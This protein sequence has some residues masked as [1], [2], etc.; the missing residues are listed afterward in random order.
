[1]DNS[2]GFEVTVNV[3]KFYYVSVTI[4]DTC[5]NHFTYFSVYIQVFKPEKPIFKSCPTR[6]ETYLTFDISLLNNEGNVKIPSC[7]VHL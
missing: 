1:M 5:L 7:C 3:T 4:K 2:S 6:Q